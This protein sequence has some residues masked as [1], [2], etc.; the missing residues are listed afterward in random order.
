MSTTYFPRRQTFWLSMVLAAAV[1]GCMVGPDYVKPPTTLAPFHN[2]GAGAT[3]ADLARW[4]AGF[5]D[6]MLAAMIDR[7]LAQNLD[8]QAAYARVQQS[9]A[10]AS[11]AGAALWPAIDLEASAGTQRQSLSSPLGGLASAQPGYRRNQQEYNVGPVASWEID[12]AGGLRRGAA[13]ARADA[14]ALDAELAGVRITVAADS[15]DAY[16]QIRGLQ[17]RI[18]VTL[19]QVDADGKLLALVQVR[20]RAGVADEREVAQADAVLKQARAALPPLRSA[21]E[22]QLNRLD[23][24]MGV[25]PGTYANALAAP[26]AMP[27]VPGIGDDASP[28]DVLRRRP[29]VMAAERR[30]AATSERIGVAVAGY[31]PRISLAGALGFDSTRAHDLFRSDAFQP[32]ATGLVRWRLFDFGRVDADIAQARGAN[33][34]A[35]ALYRHAVLK[36]AEDVENALTAFAQANLLAVERDGEV[37]ALTRARDLSTL[38]YKAGTITLTD[39]LNADRQLLFARD[40]LTSARTN[41]ARA[42]VAVFRALGGGWD[43]AAPARVAASK[44]NPPGES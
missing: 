23:V 1:S 10:A 6:P 29:D 22:A 35:L 39:V 15:A 37:A 14:E 13:A 43:P 18:A 8:V 25:Q 9:R 36:A 19:D 3:G 32:A 4:W 20:R 16:L 2:H 42:A 31:Y 40:D 5:D 21:L 27:A 24:L 11:G 44:K 41:A 26:G 30:L 38:A 12:L 17:G 33:A 7:A 34:E 28:V